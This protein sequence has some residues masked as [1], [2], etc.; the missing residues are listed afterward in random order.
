MAV[1]KIKMSQEGYNALEE[2]LEYL[3]NVTRKEIAEKLKEARSQGDLSENAEYDA[4]KDEQGIIE[5]EIKDIEYKLANSE[6]VD[7]SDLTNDEVGIGSK[8]KLKD[9]D[10][11][12]IMD[13]QIVGSTEFDPA[14]NK[15]SDDSPL[16]MAVIKARVGDVVSVE[17]PDGVIKMEVIEISK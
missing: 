8:V 5:G 10:L 2:R 11:D 12:E 1:K 7:T 14:N 16:G 15:F 6:I 4:A 13:I 9:L 17:A 3:K